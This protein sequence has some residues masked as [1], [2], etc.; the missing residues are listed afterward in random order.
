MCDKTLKLTQKVKTSK[1]TLTDDDDD[2]EDAD[3]SASINPYSSPQ[4]GKSVL[5]DAYV[6]G[7]ERRN[8]RTFSWVAA[9]YIKQNYTCTVN[10][11]S[12]TRAITAAHC[13]VLEPTPDDIKLLIFS[14][15]SE[16]RLK[17]N[18]L[19]PRMQKQ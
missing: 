13:F 10:F 14:N 19:A 15:R 2:D 17:M 18:S 4:C 6:Y 8:E 1:S 9:M 12:R 16:Y 5:I 11:I 7:G 3:L